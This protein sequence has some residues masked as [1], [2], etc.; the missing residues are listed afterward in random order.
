M[1]NLIWSIALAALGIAGL[2]L[3]GSGRWFG[4]ALGLVAQVAWILFALVTGQLG[5]I[6]SA[7]AYGFVYGRNLLRWRREHRGQ[8]RM[9]ALVEQGKH[10][11]PEDVSR[12]DSYEWHH[13]VHYDVLRSHD[14]ACPIGLDHYE[15]DLL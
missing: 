10:I 8:A 9:E 3:A 1:T 6:L 2:W 15:K 12:P 4:W 14:C 7:L 5:F 13:C 11:Y